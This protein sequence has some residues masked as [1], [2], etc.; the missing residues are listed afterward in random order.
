MNNELYILANTIY[1]KK[2]N[3]HYCMFNYDNPNDIVVL[4]KKIITI[5]KLLKTHDIDY[6]IKELKIKKETLIKI[7]CILKEYNILNNN[8]KETQE[9]LHCWLHI[10]NKCNL[11]CKYCYIL[12]NENEMNYNTAIDSINKIINKYKEENKKE[13]LLT[14]AGGEPFLNYNLMEQIILYTNKFKDINFKYRIL[15]NGTLINDKYIKFIKKNNIDIRISLDGIKE[16]NDINRCYKNGSGSYEQVIKNILLLKENNIKP[17]INIVITNNNIKGLESITKKVLSLN[18]AFRYSLEKTN[19]FKLPDLV[20]NQNKLIKY[21]K[22]CFKLILKE[23]EKR[24][25]YFGFD[26]IKF[27]NNTCKTCEAGYNTFA[28]SEKGNIA[29]CGMNLNKAKYNIKAYEINDILNKI[30]IENKSCNNCRWNK[31][32]NGG[33]PLFNY[34]NKLNKSPYCKTYKHI[35]PMLFKIYAKNKLIN[36]IK[37]I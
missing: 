13:I 23:Q 5:I 22:K 7:L 17:T 32:C 20:N 30:K 37:D 31:V 12:K 1:I 18:V 16:Y 34:S 19:E 21:L 14:F 36:N 11:D 28:I 8:N 27:N 24:E 10:T 4:D 29:I 25:V 6:I 33:C 35:I 2:I 3:K 9:T 26:D 15:T